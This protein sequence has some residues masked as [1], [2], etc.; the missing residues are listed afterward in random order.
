MG[1]VMG[2]VRTVVRLLTTR[3]AKQLDASP[4]MGNAIRLLNVQLAVRAI[5]Y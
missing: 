3:I 1:F 4:E 5:A 2:T